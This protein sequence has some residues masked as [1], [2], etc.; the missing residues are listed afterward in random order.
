LAALVQQASRDLDETCQ[1]RH[2]VGQKKYGDF[3]F[4][5]A[6]TIEMAMEEIAD[7]MNYMR[8][9]WIKLWL[10]QRSVARQAQEHPAQ[11]GGWVPLKEM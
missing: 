2:E 7:M 5:D 8:Y 10:L 4:F 3:T 9:T 11:S 1:T 6:D